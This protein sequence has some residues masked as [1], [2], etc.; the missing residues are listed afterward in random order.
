MFITDKPKNKKKFVRLTKKDP[1]WHQSDGLGVYPR[2]G[3][4]FHA[5][6]PAS[7]VLLIQQ[8]FQNGWL[9]QSVYIPEK[10]LMWETLQK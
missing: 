7:V 8:A 10:T 3:I 1:R 5:Q 6:C 4:E 9:E 2:A